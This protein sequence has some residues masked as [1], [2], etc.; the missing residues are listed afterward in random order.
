MWQFSL[1]NIQFRVC[2][3]GL[4]NN[5]CIDIMLGWQQSL[6]LYDGGLG[7]NL[8]LDMMLELATISVLI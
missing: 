6:S 5:L 3:A 4:G 2:D 1:S 8:R 7:N